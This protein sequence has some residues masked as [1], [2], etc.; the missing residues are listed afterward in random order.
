MLLSI[1]LCTFSS[2]NVN[3]QEVKKNRVRLKADY[4]KVMG[5]DSYFDIKASAK[6]EKKNVSVS[7][8]EVI[9]YHELDDDQKAAN[10]HNVV[11]Q[12]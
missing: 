2:Q 4:V 11:S 6:I 7:N 8:I 10:A 9:I 12:D 5:S 1:L 3:G